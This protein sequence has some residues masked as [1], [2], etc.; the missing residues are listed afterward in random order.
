[1]Q[2]GETSTAICAMLVW[3]VQALCNASCIYP[4][5]QDAW[6]HKNHYKQGVVVY[7]TC[8][9]SVLSALMQS[10]H[11]QVV[12]MDYEC[13]VNHERCLCSVS[14]RA[15][16]A[17]PSETFNTCRLTASSKFGPQ[18]AELRGWRGWMP[19]SAQLTGNG[20]SAVLIAPFCLMCDQ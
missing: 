16:N 11:H 12:R 6:V 19:I 3:T 15:V 18:V 7:G 2:G 5:I 17:P 9:L 8:V 20:V 10:S 13:R 4:A 1:M 14:L